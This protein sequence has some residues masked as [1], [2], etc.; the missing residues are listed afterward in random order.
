MDTVTLTVEE[1]EDLV[2]ARDHAVAMRGVASGIIPVLSQ[3]EAEAYLAA[4]TPLAFWRE[5]RGLALD[6][7]AARA[8]V[9]L[10]DVT[11]I[12]DGTLVGDV[13]VYSRLA[14]VLGVRIEDLLAE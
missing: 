6:G 7:L 5:H 9:A 14:R 10:G 4:A 8:G 12:E 1:Y 3:E 13:M 11:A 2:D